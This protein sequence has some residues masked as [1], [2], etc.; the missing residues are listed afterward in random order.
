MLQYEVFSGD[1]RR[2]D[3]CACRSRAE[4]PHSARHPPPRV[5]CCGRAGDARAA[6]ARRL[7][8]QRPDGAHPERLA[9][10]GPA[11]RGRRS[12]R[13]T[14][15]HHATGSLDLDDTHRRR[16]VLHGGATRVVRPVFATRGAAVSV[17]RG[18]LLVGVL[19]V[20]AVR[21]R[22]PHQKPHQIE[23]L[24]LPDRRADRRTCR[25]DRLRGSRLGCGIE[26]PRRREA[27]HRDQPRLPDWRSPDLG[28]CGRVPLAR[29]V[30][31]LATLDAVDPRVRHAGRQ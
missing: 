6:G 16:R 20:H 1:V 5:R 25:L 3:G 27:R 9:D 30:A 10:G 22:G 31:T 28:V 4:S 8:R 7:G 12:D 26:H 23:T 14:C 2:N 11:G 24:R 19:P 29:P 17:D 21:V 13:G 18:S 15:A